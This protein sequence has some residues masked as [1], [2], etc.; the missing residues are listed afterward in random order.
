MRSRFAAKPLIRLD[1]PWISRQILVYPKLYGIDKIADHHSVIFRNRPVNQAFVSF[2]QITHGGH[3]PYRQPLSSPFLYLRS[4]F[5]DT[6]CDFHN[7]SPFSAR[8]FPAV[9][10]FAKWG[11]RH[12]RLALCSHRSALC[13]RK[14]A[15][16]FYCP[17]IQWKTLIW[18]CAARRCS[19]LI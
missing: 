4:Y 7:D 11:C 10:A 14:K 1:I 17:D 15:R 13:S 3:K 16:A 19:H 2:M 5:S 6:S 18:K 12:P 8:P 9:A